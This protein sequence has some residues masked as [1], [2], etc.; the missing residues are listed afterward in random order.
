MDRHM[1]EILFYGSIIGRTGEVVALTGVDI[2]HEWLWWFMRLFM[3]ERKE[4]NLKK[5]KKKNSIY[6]KQEFEYIIRK[7]GGGERE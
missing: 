2:A 5:K 3:K 1:T 7:A 6:I 4:I